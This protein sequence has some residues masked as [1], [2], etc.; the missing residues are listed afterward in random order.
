MRPTL[1]PGDA[2]RV[3]GQFANDAYTPAGSLE[4]N[5]FF[6]RQV[7][8]R[9]PRDADGAIAYGLWV[10]YASATALVVLGP[11]AFAIWRTVH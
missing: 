1:P 6:W 11:I 4:R 7:K 8:R 9:G 2:Q 3:F 10:L 5:G